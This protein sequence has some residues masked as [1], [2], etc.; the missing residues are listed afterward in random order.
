MAKMAD[1]Y[2]LMGKIQLIKYNE[3]LDGSGLNEKYIEYQKVLNGSVNLMYF[4]RAFS[5]FTSCQLSVLKSQFTKNEMVDIYL[6]HSLC[7]INPAPFTIYL[8]DNIH[9]L[10]DVLEGVITEMF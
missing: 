1:D 10:R 6:I 2:H 3:W 4:M 8:E 7:K 9:I 5:I